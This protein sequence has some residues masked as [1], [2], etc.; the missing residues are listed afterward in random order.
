MIFYFVFFFQVGESLRAF[1]KAE[2]MSTKGC[3]ESQIINTVQ[4]MNKRVPLSKLCLNQN[5]FN[6][7]KEEI[8]YLILFLRNKSN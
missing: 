1:L 2:E 5:L 3:T 8:I 6:L 7:L 4:D